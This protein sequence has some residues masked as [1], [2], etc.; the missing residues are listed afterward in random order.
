MTWVDSRDDHLQPTRT[1]GECRRHATIC[2]ARPG[3]A[4]PGPARP[5]TWCHYRS[6]LVPCEVAH[7]EP[8]STPASSGR[9]DQLFKLFRRGC[10][11][12]G[13]SRRPS[14]MSLLRVLHNFTMIYNNLTKLST[15]LCKWYFKNTV[16][17]LSTSDSAHHLR[18]HPWFV[19]SLLIPAKQLSEEM[20]LVRTPTFSEKHGSVICMHVL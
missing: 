6:S 11:L 20:I 13:C 14:L 9:T 16:H 15:V 7:N 12:A 4:R 5:R 18:R 17:F 2:P 8:L 3:P 10:P 19:V 1:C